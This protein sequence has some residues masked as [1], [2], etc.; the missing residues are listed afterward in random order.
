[1]EHTRQREGACAEERS[2][3]SAWS[4]SLISAAGRN[5]GAPDM[6]E[7]QEVKVLSKAG[8]SDRSETQ[9]VGPRGRREGS[10]E[11]SRGPMDKNRI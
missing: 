7:T 2:D 5:Q 4:L 8:C 9:S 3:D 11:R 6:N 1:M 10:V